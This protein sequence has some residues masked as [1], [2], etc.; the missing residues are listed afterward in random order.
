MSSPD[1]KVEAELRALAAR[2]WRIAIA[3]T[4]AMMAAYFGFLFLVA[5]AKPTAGALVY[6]GLSWGILL[7]VLVIVVA[8][9]VTGVYVIWANSQYDA[10]LARLRRQIAIADG[11]NDGSDKSAKETV[12]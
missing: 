5:F 8:W 7:G 4:G 3:L 2:R 6:R 9:V 1:A 12:D 10:E 11:G